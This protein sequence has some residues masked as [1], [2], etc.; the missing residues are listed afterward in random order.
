[1]LIKI[2]WEIKNML[3]EKAGVPVYW[4]VPVELRKLSISQLKNYLKI[5]YC[6]NVKKI[7]VIY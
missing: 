4:K 7:E 3:P 6:Y 1:M 5:K 2:D